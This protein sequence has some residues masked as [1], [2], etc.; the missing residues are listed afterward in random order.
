LTFANSRPLP[1]SPAVRATAPS[2]PSAHGARLLIE[3]S[4]RHL[5]D[6][7]AASSEPIKIVEELHLAASQAF[8]LARREVGQHIHQV[9]IRGRPAARR[10]PLEKDLTLMGA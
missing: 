6:G 1:I 9:F 7:G 8:L 5:R 3:R 10:S 4:R 2:V